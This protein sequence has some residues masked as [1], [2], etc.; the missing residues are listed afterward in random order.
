MDKPLWKRDIVSRCQKI[1]FK[2]TNKR[3][4]QRVVSQEEFVKRLSLISFLNH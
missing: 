4:K 2:R 1:N 3:I